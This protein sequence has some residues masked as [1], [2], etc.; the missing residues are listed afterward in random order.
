MSDYITPNFKMQKEDLIKA[1]ENA[2]SRHL[3]SGMIAKVIVNNLI[4]SPVGLNQ[5][6]Q[7]FLGVEP[8]TN[9]CVGD[10]VWV[11][12]KNL[13]TWRLNLPEMQKKDLIFQEKVECVITKIDLYSVSP[14]G[15]EFNGITDALEMT[16]QQYEIDLHE[17]E[18]SDSG[19]IDLLDD[20][21]K[22]EQLP[23]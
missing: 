18:L 12:V 20:E 2:L 4:K 5:L 10:K 13:P 19:N 8:K 15:I 3:Y 9:F 7:S 21:D 11:L 14:L 16:T 1:L 6:I 23:F 22:P 17:A